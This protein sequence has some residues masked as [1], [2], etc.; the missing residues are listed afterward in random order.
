MHVLPQKVF[1]P[2]N[3]KLSLFYFFVF[4]LKDNFVLVSAQKEKTVMHLFLR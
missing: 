2:K 3:Y 1:P 4:F